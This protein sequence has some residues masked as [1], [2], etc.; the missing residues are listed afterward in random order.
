VADIATQI[1]HAVEA[2]STN[3]QNQ[4]R[5]LRELLD[6]SPAVFQQ[7]VAAMLASARDTPEL[8]YVIALLSAR[9]MLVPMLRDLSSSDRGAAGVVAQLAQRMDPRFDRSIARQAP[10]AK[11]P[12]DRARPNPEFLLGLLDALSGGL[13]L[14]PLLAP[15]RESEDPKIRARMALL[16]GRIT[17]AQ[18]WF[19]TLEHDPDPRV[20]ANVVESLWS[21]EGASSLACFERSLQ[22]RHHRVVANALVGLYLQGATTGVSGLVRLA[23]HHESLF[24]AAATWAMG[25]TGD[26]RFL[27]VLRQ[28][29]R[30]PDQDSMVVRNA[31]HAIARINQATIAAT[32]RETRV[33][34]LRRAAGSNSSLDAHFVALDRESGPLP[35]L[36]PTDWQIRANCQPIWNYQADFVPPSARLALGVVI[37]TAPAEDANRLPLCESALRAADQWRRPQDQF[38]ASLYSESAGS[39]FQG[40]ALEPLS[41]GAPPKPQPVQAFK[42]DPTVLLAAAHHSADPTESLK[43]LASLL[44]PSAGDSHLIL[45]LDAIPESRCDSAGVASL[46]T[47]LRERG[48]RLHALITGRAVPCLASAFHQ[49]TLDTGGFSLHCPE[50]EDLAS[51]LQTLIAS[52]FGH[53]QIQCPLPEP[54]EQIEVELQAE[55]HQGKLPLPAA[56]SSQ[57]SR[58][59]A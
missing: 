9:G 26:T 25:R 59:A 38:A 4:G 20:R 3:S 56:N 16:L 33:I 41:F 28:M 45:V 11:A 23:Q 27:P 19:Q 43:H 15:L 21:V 58:V 42:N 29:R 22:D 10:E 35:I 44:D 31:L 49:L 46:L 36:K 57:Y 39:H 54:V 53:Y 12:P 50:I 7:V 1:R 37:P 48:I 30:G 24:R 52:T 40:A 5:R 34:C 47:T 17:R 2:L 8:R 6:E 14:L 51:S 55:G 32:R 18:D 13:C